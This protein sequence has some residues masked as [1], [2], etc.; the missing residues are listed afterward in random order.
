MKRKTRTYVSIFLV[1]TMV[2][3]MP[4]FA[5]EDVDIEISSKEVIVESEEPIDIHN[6]VKLPDDIEHIKN[7]VVSNEIKTKDKLESNTNLSLD[8]RSITE[9]VIVNRLDDKRILFED[10]KELV[11]IYE[12]Q[13]TI[14]EE[15]ATRS[16]IVSGYRVD[17]A[18]YAYNNMTINLTSR[19]DFEKDYSYV[20]EGETNPVKMKKTTYSFE[21]GSAYYNN[22]LGV[23]KIDRE[24]KQYGPPYP[25]GNYSA[26]N[27]NGT[28]KYNSFTFS[29]SH[30]INHSPS[31]FSLMKDG[32]IGG[33]VYVDAYFYVRNYVI[34]PPYNSWFVKKEP[35]CTSY[36]APVS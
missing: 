31:N 14:E 1:F 27:Y 35:R 23:E 29:D 28:K 25:S 18:Y 16:S 36:G 12:V 26:L 19:V 4:V 24:A 2:L 10:D 33:Y 34:A 21:A 8:G 5:V 13:Y 7:D 22:R 30:Y 20:G 6:Y 11:L 17:S 32:I 9:E 15:A 3:S